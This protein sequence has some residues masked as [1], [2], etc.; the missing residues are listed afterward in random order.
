[1]T[2]QR[3][4]RLAAGLGMLTGLL[5]LLTGLLLAKHFALVLQLAIVNDQSEIFAEMREK[6]LRSD[7]AEAAGYLE[8]V[9]SYYPSGTKLTHGSMADRI[10]ER[11][12]ACA[13][14][15]I[16]A[17]LRAKTGLDLGADPGPWIKRFRVR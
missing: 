8:F 3:Y 2:I 16:I 5:L 1:M 9:V 7:P 6:A 15:D 4:K 10:V 14:S 11:D 12:R 17:Y 13:V